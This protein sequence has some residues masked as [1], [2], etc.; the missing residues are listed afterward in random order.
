MLPKH[1]HYGHY[2][3]GYSDGNGHG[4]VRYNAPDGWGVVF[5]F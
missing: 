2:P 3:R 5:K 1:R 4:R